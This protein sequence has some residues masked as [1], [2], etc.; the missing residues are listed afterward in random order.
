MHFCKIVIPQ[1]SY[2]VDAVNSSYVIIILDDTYQITL[3]IQI[4][5]LFTKIDAVNLHLQDWKKKKPLRPPL[6]PVV[7]QQCLTFP[8]RSDG[9]CLEQKS[10]H[11][12][13]IALA[14][15]RML[16]RCL[17]AR[18][19]AHRPITHEKLRSNT[20]Q[21]DEQSHILH[22]SPSASLLNP[23]MHRHLLNV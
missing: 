3:A 8:D 5:F 7:R 21:A 13:I 2:V 15:W 20:Q 17:S 4:S 22:A 19:R 14:I 6:F 12:S 16:Q 18:L 1:S 10:T 11:V 9:V 23:L